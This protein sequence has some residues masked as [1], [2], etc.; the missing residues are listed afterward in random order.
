MVGAIK[1]RNPA[2]FVVLDMNDARLGIRPGQTSK[3]GTGNNV[4][5]SLR[6]YWVFR[7]KLG[8]LVC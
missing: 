8:N 6:I 4:V 2:T 3:T 1:T 7:Q 5:K